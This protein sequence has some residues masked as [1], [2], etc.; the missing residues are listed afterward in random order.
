MAKS[1]VFHGARALVLMPTTPGSAPVVVGVFN[2]V[3][4]V[5]GL[6]DAEVDILGA[7]APV[8]ITYV[9]ASPV[10]AEATGWRIVGHGPH[11]VAS[12]PHLKDLLLFEGITI[13]IQDRQAKPGD[14]PVCTIKNVLPLGYSGGVAA[15]QLSEIRVSFKGTRI[16]DETGNND[17]PGAATLPLG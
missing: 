3:S 14:L 6:I 9:G 17:E 13:Q 12:V 7:Y 16:E 11:V 2:N 10:T 5:Y 1:Q 4:W 8:E 15:K